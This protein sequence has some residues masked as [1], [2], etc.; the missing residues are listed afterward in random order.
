MLGI[1]TACLRLQHVTSRSCM[2]RAQV[3]GM[4]QSKMA[5]GLAPEANGSLI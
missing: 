2:L 5:L 1:L 4:K 3:V